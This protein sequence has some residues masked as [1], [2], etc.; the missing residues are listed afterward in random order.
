MNQIQYIIHELFHWRSVL[1]IVIIATGIFFLHRTFVRLGTWK[2]LMGIA[3]AFLLYSL[4][5]ILNLEGLEWVFQNVSQVAVLAVIVIFQPE[6]RKL[7][8][9][10]VSIYGRKKISEKNDLT[11][12]VAESLWQIG[13]R[14]QGALIVYPGRETIKDKISGG[15]ISNAEASIALIMSIFDPNSPGHDGAM[16]IENN[17]IA[18]FGVRLPMS[19]SQQLDEQYGTRHHAA[20]GLA[21]ATD[22][23]VLLVSEE[24]G[25]VSAFCNGTM[26][27]LDSVS[28]IEDAIATHRRRHDQLKL[29][30]VVPRD[31]RTFLQV[32]GSLGAAVVFW[33][34]LSTSNKEVIERAFTLPID[35]S[36]PSSGLVLVGEQVDEARV[37]VTGPHSAVNDFILTRPSLR[38]DLSAMS[39]GTQT[40]LIATD[41]IASGKISILSVS[42]G[43]VDVTLEKY[44]VTA[45]PVKPQL[46]G[47]LPAGKKLKSVSVIPPQISVL[48]SNRHREAANNRL[49]GPHR[50]I[51]LP[52]S[53]AAVSSVR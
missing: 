8:E 45:L 21:E 28:S 52:F 33:I 4:A 7:L 40:A 39:E 51:F 31:R 11:K 2:Q 23:L 3:A 5:S 46:V 14:K 35:Y 38:V 16:I 10:I 42:P 9:K 15:H 1:D 43:Q 6:L 25:T 47:I 27:K 49:S 41:H 13:Q 12:M 37:K 17:R 29:E 30:S 20:M 44:V 26:R 36:A 34:V 32:T 22:S 18:Q 48:A 50:S 19:Q 53:Q 24:R